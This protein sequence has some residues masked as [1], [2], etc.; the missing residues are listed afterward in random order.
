MPKK[1]PDRLIDAMTALQEFEIE[2]KSASDRSVILFGSTLLEAAVESL[3]VAS[4]HEDTHDDLLRGSGRLTFSQCIAVSYG[5]GAISADERGDLDTIRKIRNDAAHQFAGV[6]FGS[7]SISSRCSNLITG[8][9]LY[10]PDTIPFPPGLT[11]ELRLDSIS[12]EQLPRIELEFPGASKPREI[13]AATVRALMRVLAARHT[14][15]S[16]GVVRQRV[17]ATEFEHAEDVATVILD[18]LELLTRQ[19]T[20][21][22]EQL[23]SIIKSVRHRLADSTDLQRAETEAEIKRIEAEILGLNPTTVLKM[24]EVSRYTSRVLKRSRERDNNSEV[25]ESN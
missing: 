2:V 8:P 11:R 4:L 6:S 1:M 15:V 3:L 5:I 9:R 14:R 21:L 12:D 10:V 16:Y 18:H 13:F 25:R 23:R 22:H 19:Q 24:A 20:D 17:N 7:N